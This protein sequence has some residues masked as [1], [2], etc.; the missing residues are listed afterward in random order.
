MA[1]KIKLAMTEETKGIIIT[2]IHSNMRGVVRGS[3]VYQDENGKLCLFVKT[4]YG[5]GSAW[6]SLT[7]C[8]MPDG[9]VWIGIHEGKTQR[10]KVIH[11]NFYRN[12]I[13]IA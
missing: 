11:A 1:T 7:G 2:A 4:D 13:R 6:G 5:D 12:N 10:S 8:L 9:L 3:E